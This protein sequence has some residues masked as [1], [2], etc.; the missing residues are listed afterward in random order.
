[1]KVLAG[2]LILADTAWLA[3]ANAKPVLLGVFAKF[4]ANQFPLITAPVTVMLSAVL[5]AE[6]GVDHLLTL[7]LERPGGASTELAAATMQLKRSGRPSN[8][9][10]PLPTMALAEPGVHYIVA[11]S[12][13]VEI[14]RVGFEVELR[15][16]AHLEH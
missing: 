5:E 16:P 7:S 9:P 1:M 2:N 14:A 6:E 3:T 10:L 13:D 12:G 4:Y 15:V 8:L 11:K